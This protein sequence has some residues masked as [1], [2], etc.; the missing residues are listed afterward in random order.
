MG[1]LEKRKNSMTV[2]LLLDTID[3]LERVTGI[4]FG[5]TPALRLARFFLGPS[6][7]AVLQSA[8][9]AV[10]QAQKQLR[11]ALRDVQR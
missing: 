10:G 11:A 8:A 4:D 1:Q 5:P 7:E 3:A 2:A 9:D 6:Y